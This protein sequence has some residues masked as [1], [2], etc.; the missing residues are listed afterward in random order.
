MEVEL[1]P[2]TLD[3]AA[4]LARV[5]VDSWRV[6][7][8]GLVPQDYLDALT[9]EEREEG[10]EGRLRQDG[11]EPRGLVV[12]CRIG[13]FVTL[14]EARSEDGGPAVGEL[15]GIYL[16]P[17]LFGLGLGR[18]LME[19]SLQ[20]LCA[21]GHTEAVL[22]VLDGNRRAERFYEAAGWQREDA[23]RRHPR[24]GVPLR[25]YRRS[26]GDARVSGERP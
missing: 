2:A 16:H 17:T 14:V 13:G 22:W 7:Y 12:D 6:A 5:S 25:R 20:R 18:Q 26:L 1:R 4:G 21:R 3:D 24:L 11:A 15:E 10:W 23:V 9:Y 8:Q 19:L